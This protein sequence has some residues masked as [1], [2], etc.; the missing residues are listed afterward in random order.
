MMRMNGILAD[1]DIHDLINN[2]MVNAIYSLDEKQ[3]QPASLD[4]RLGNKA[5]RIR[6]SFMPGPDA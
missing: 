3:I 6:A 1:S 4:L 5:Y 2:G